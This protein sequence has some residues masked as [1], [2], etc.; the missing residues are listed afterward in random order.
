MMHFHFTKLARRLIRAHLERSSSEN[1][2]KRGRNK[3]LRAFQYAAQCSS[4]YQTLLKE[5]DVAISQIK[6]VE[7]FIRYC[8][9]LEKTNTFRRFPIEKLLI[10]DVDLSQLASILTS[11][12]H[13]KGG[14][15]MGLSTRYQ[16]KS[17][18][19]LIDLGL[20]LAFNVDQQRTLLIN[21][22]P[23]GV[24]FQSQAVC[25]ANVS[26][27]EDMVCAIVEQA[28]HLFEQIILCA[29]PLFLKHLCDYAE[30]KGLQWAQY[31]M[32]AIIGEET[33]TESFR[34]YL[35][36]CLGMNSQATHRGLIL[37]SMGVGELGLNLF[38]ETRESIALKQA[39]INNSKLAQALL[40]NITDTPIPTLLC[41]NPL[42]IFA[43]II[44]A[45]TAGKGELIISTLD[46]PLIPLLRYKTGDQAMLLDSN[47]VAQ[48]LQ[49]FQPDLKLPPLP[50]IALYGRSKDFLTDGWHVDHFKEALYQQPELARECSGAFH[51]S[52]SEQGLL[53]EVQLRAESA[54]NPLAHAAA[55]SNCL[56]T[57]G[58][59]RLPQV[60]CIEYEKFPYGK[61]LDYE[62]KF[63]YFGN[64]NIISPC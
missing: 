11:S 42:H 10:K 39:C 52:L 2:L 63:S 59:D 29:D 56:V 45:D 50:M 24:T 27:R 13:G 46:K 32:H 8:P 21:C 5:N 58:K 54:V 41:Y 40:G 62:R 4:A 37:S 33:F 64:E 14:F 3:L 38:H 20:D 53:W 31:K 19:F 36:T 15:A 6:T 9:I 1:L 60:S 23:M 34:R 12:G 55:L 51:L 28:G 25:V 44:N 30:T 49:Q 43:E 17:A 18:P 57:F 61:T 22:L 26:V 47:Q 35:A 16:Y 7:D 48:L